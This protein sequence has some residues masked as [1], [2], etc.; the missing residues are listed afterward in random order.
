M[1]TGLRFWAG[2]AGGAPAVAAARSRA[3]SGSL[4][5]YRELIEGA[6]VALA[7]PT[8]DKADTVDASS[9]ASLLNEAGIHL[10]SKADYQAAE[11]LLRRALAI[12]EQSLGPDHPEVATNLNNLARLLQDTNRRSEAEPLLR[13]ALAIF[14]SSLG[15]EH[16]TTVTVRE[17]LELLLASMG[18]EKT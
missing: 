7:V 18:G 1:R 14:E 12:N 3:S 6:Q 16:P 10:L 15:P 2:P 11:P 4:V 13:R 9:C 17:N 5:H 8:W